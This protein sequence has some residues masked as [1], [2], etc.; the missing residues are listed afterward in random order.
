MGKAHIVIG[1][2]LFTG[3]FT[4]P[5]YRSGGRAGLTWFEWVME[6]TIFGSPIQYVPEE[7][8]IRELE[9][10]KT[11]SLQKAGKRV[12]LE[13]EGTMYSGSNVAELYDALAQM[14]DSLN[15]GGKARLLM[16]SEQLPTQQELDDAFIESRANGL[17]LS[18]F[19]A[20]IVNGRAVTQVILRKGSPA[21]QVALIIPAAI[22]IGMIIFGILGERI[23]KALVPILLIVGG[24]AVAIA[25]ASGGRRVPVRARY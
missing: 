20:K 19:T 11:L 14:E 13:E 15:I 18:R 21:W 6:H 4:V 5:V 3:A 25:V 9:G 8:Y 22:L 10:V 2:L 12:E 1:G 16:V 23:S 7:D 17:H 24:S